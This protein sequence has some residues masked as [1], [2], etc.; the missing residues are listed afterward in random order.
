[1]VDAVQ[2]FFTSS[3]IGTQRLIVVVCA[4]RQFGDAGTVPCHDWNGTGVAGSWKRTRPPHQ[5]SSF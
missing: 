3:L 5:I 1:V 4:C 2:I